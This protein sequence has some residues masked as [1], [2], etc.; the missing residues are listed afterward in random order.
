MVNPTP[1][2]EWNIKQK[3]L[4]DVE[5]L[6]SFLK[7]TYGITGLFFFESLLTAIVGFLQKNKP[8]VLRM[9]PFLALVSFLQTSISFFCLSYDFDLETAQKINNTAVFVY[10]LVEFLII[11]QLTLGIT[12]TRILRYIMFFPFWS[13]ILFSIYV[14]YNADFSVCL[15]VAF[16]ISNSFCIV[17]P[18]LFYFY[19]TFKSPP[20]NNL[21]QD[22]CFWVITGYLF[23]SICT[24]PF[25]ALEDYIF[26]N[27]IHLYHQVCMLNTVFYC[28]L[29]LLILKSFK[30]RQTTTK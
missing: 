11:Y 27:L 16:N 28:L 3:P 13:F 17:V 8:R 29:F 24:L 6:I 22:P 5:Q 26:T 18:C 7:E 25:Y 2:G 1:S 15:P 12:K 20:L 30:C 10:I 4:G 21:S 14:Y 19:E 9:L 23:M